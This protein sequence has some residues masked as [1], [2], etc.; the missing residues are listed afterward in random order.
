MQASWVGLAI[1]IVALS[2]SLSLQ[3]WSLHIQGSG[4]D[5]KKKAIEFN[6]ASKTALIAAII[7]FV[8]AV[9]FIVFNACIAHAGN[10]NL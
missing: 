3:S 5:K 9:I 2:V 8:L 1:A 4:D 6:Q 7:L 10:L